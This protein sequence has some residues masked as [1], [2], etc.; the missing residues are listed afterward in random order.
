MRKPIRPARQPITGLLPH[1]QYLIQLQKLETRIFII[2]DAIEEARDTI[3]RL[4]DTLYD[5]KA[6][7]PNTFVL[8]IAV[9]GHCLWKHDISLIKLHRAKE[10]LILIQEEYIPAITASFEAFRN[11]TKKASESEETWLSRIGFELDLTPE[12]IEETYVAN[13][14]ALCERGLRKHAEFKRSL[15]EAFP[16]FAV[17]VNAGPPVSWG[18]ATPCCHDCY[19]DM[20]QAMKAEGDEDR[21][22]MWGAEGT[23]PCEEERKEQREKAKMLAD[24]NTKRL[25]NE[26]KRAK[27]SF[28]ASTQEGLRVAYGFG[29]DVHYR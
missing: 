14:L 2:Q 11:N 3:R 18:G 7:F 17:F 28:L 21:G 22:G 16:G 25:V 1:Q 5:Y 9:L 20:A 13:M 27:W 24:E 29:D 12:R 23:V 4:T 10:K 15:G 26:A 8:P 6:A 19:R